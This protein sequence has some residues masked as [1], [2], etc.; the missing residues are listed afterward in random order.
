MFHPFIAAGKSYGSADQ[1]QAAQCGE[2]EYQDCYGRKVLYD[3]ERFP[4]FDSHDLLYENRYFHTYLIQ[5]GATWTF[6]KITDED[7]EVRV[8]ENLSTEELGKYIRSRFMDRIRS[9]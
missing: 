6:V 8:I 7:P 9:K 1:L 4:C 2:W 5:T 3:R